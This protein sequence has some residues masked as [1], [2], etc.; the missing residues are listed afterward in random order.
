MST[1]SSSSDSDCRKKKSRKLSENEEK[2]IIR[3]YLDSKKKCKTKSKTKPRSPS[4]VKQKRIKIRAPSRSPE[5]EEEDHVEIPDRQ[6][7][8]HEHSPWS[9]RPS[10]SPWTR[11]RAPFRGR[12]NFSS[13]TWQHSFEATVK[14]NTNEL[15]NLSDKIV[16]LIEVVKINNSMRMEI[17]SALPNITQETLNAE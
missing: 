9:G 1:S 3:K 8:V 17:V 16:Q 2:E 13:S 10:R 14:E 7:I 15:R 11:G 12:G 6:V 5:K 4:P